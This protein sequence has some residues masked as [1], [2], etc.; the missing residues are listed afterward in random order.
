VGTE[1]VLLQILIKQSV[2]SLTYVRAVLLACREEEEGD[3]SQVKVSM[4]EK[5]YEKYSREEDVSDEGRL[6][7][8]KYLVE[9]KS[10]CGSDK[11]YRLDCKSTRFNKKVSYILNQT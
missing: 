4:L 1:S 2:G 8:D 7:L 6:L 11:D 3:V 10:I 5:L 9:L